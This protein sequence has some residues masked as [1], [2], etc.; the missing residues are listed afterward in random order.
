MR[1]PRTSADPVVPDRVLAV[2]APLV[3]V[4]TTVATWWLVGDLSSRMPPGTDLDYA[5]GPW[6]I[7]P[8]LETTAGIAASVVTVAVLVAAVV[9]VVAGRLR[10]P[11]L[12]LLIGLLGC[13]VVIGWAARALTAGGI[14]ANI[15]AGLV[16]LFVAPLLGVALLLALGRAWYLVRHP[17]RR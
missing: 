14:G 12:T 10:S 13:G 1:D 3:L 9:A 17:R 5:F 2:A 7:D 16:V 8:L 11:W 15:G 4:P 6:P